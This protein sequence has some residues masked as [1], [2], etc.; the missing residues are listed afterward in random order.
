[1]IRR[2]ILRITLVFLL[3]FLAFSRSQGQVPS[4]QSLL[5]YLPGADGRLVSWRT[6]ANY[7]QKVDDASD[8]VSVRVL[9]KTTEGRPKP[10]AR[11]M[12]HLADP[13]RRRRTQSVKDGIPS[14]S[15]GTSEG[16][17]N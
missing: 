17:E 10:V 1:M 13:V 8:R 14:Q 9:G 7:F 11:P 2:L 16:S 3:S 5:G 4:P 15:V 12:Q 6:V